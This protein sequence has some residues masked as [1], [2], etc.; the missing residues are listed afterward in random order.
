MKLLSLNCNHCGAPIQVPESVNFV[1]CTHCNASLKIERS[2]GAVFTTIAE[3]LVKIENHAADI[4]AKVDVLSIERELDA[5]HREWDNTRERSARFDEHGVKSYPFEGPEIF[6]V[7]PLILMSAI[8]I[9]GFLALMLLMYQQQE[10][11]QIMGFVLFGE[12]AFFIRSLGFGVE[13]RNS[14]Q[15]A[16]LRYQ[17]KRKKVLRRLQEAR[18]RLKESHP[19]L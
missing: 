12:I 9:T 8:I 14:Y 3:N 18:S 7:H 15:Q 2:E 10:W 1:T 5:L 4:S 13:G 19:R 6:N 11:A 17:Q 16:R